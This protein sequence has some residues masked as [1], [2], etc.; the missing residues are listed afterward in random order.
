[1]KDPIEQHLADNMNHIRELGKKAIG[2]ERHLELLGKEAADSNLYFWMEGYMNSQKKEAT[3]NTDIPIQPDNKICTCKCN[4]M[5]Q[6]YEGIDYCHKCALEIKNHNKPDVNDIDAAKMAE[7]YSKT[8]QAD[9]TRI[10][11][12]G[13]I[14]Q[15]VRNQFA[16]DFALLHHEQRVKECL[17][18]VNE[19]C[20]RIVYRMQQE[21]PEKHDMVKQAIEDHFEQ[22]EK[23][24]FSDLTKTEEG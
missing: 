10:D 17:P 20:E 1:M 22:L 18:Y 12:R 5:I 4:R 19:I 23:R 21:F 13:D 16:A 14:Q 7:E 24:L 11:Q 8:W 15:Q 6:H 3:T 9:M 2:Y